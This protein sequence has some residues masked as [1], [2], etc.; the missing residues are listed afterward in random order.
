MKYVW[1]VQIVVVF[2][3]KINSLWPLRGDTNLIYGDDY[4]N[5]PLSKMSKVCTFLAESCG[6]CTELKA[7]FWCGESVTGS[8]SCF[9]RSDLVA[10][11]RCIGKVVSYWKRPCREINQNFYSTEDTE[12]SVLV[13]L[14]LLLRKLRDSQNTSNNK[15]AWHKNVIPRLQGTSP[16]ISFNNLGD[17][18]NKDLHDRIGFLTNLSA[19]NTMQNTVHNIS[20]MVN[21]MQNFTVLADKDNRNVSL[22]STA[23][24]NATESPQSYKLNSTIISSHKNN[25]TIFCSLNNQTSCIRK[26]FCSWCSNNSCCASFKESGSNGIVLV[27]SEKYQGK[28]E[29]SAVCSD[30]EGCETCVADISCYWCQETSSCRKYPG[31]S[32]VAAECKGSLY[33][34]TCNQQIPVYAIAIWIMLVTFFVSVGYICIR[35]CYYFQHKP[36]EVKLE[37]R[38]ILFKQKNGRT[39]Y[40]ITESEEEDEE[41]LSRT[42]KDSYTPSKVGA[43]PNNPAVW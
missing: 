7:C 10:R 5:F 22:N 42:G 13:K 15:K 32:Y 8:G 34:R 3:V 30:M 33:H 1:L 29:T 4:N 31:K 38:P 43:A 6:K 36:V 18:S 27:T 20:A 28:N 23:Q 12:R 17:M 14:L 21:G 2:L 41:L 26:M 11:Q 35:K 19:Y 40:Q 25:A 37:E 16:P 24:Q 9:A 39:V